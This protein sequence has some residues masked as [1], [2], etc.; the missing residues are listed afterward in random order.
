MS[1]HLGAS[2]SSSSGSG[3]DDRPNK[4]SRRDDFIGPIR[5]LTGRA[6]GAVIAARDSKGGDVQPVQGAAGPPVPANIFLNQSSISLLVRAT[7]NN[8]LS[9]VVNIRTGEI[10]VYPLTEEAY[11]LQDD[12][13]FRRGAD[14]YTNSRFPGALPYVEGVGYP[15]EEDTPA[16]PLPQGATRARAMS[17][18]DPPRHITPL[19]HMDPL[20]GNEVSH[21]QIARRVGGI[22]TPV[23]DVYSNFVGFTVW[24]AYPNFSLVCTSRALNG[25]KFNRGGRMNMAWANAI[26][27]AFTNAHLPKP[28]SADDLGLL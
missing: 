3:D 9:G 26:C 24:V 16:R 12:P 6:C 18:S 20:W 27:A 22:P 25:N 14:G 10:T 21:E 5:T 2:S 7:T 23:N 13:L 11:P 19:R 17:V 8:A 15:Q 28:R 4:R 1:A